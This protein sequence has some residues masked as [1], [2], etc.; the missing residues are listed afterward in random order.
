[1]SRPGERHYPEQIVL[2]VSPELRLA[3][4]RAAQD[5]DRTLASLTRRLLERAVAERSESATV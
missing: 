4:E 1:M 5:E 2:R 3:L